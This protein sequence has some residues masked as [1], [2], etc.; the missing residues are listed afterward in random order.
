[1]A[2]LRSMDASRVK[3]SLN[4]GSWWIV[5]GPSGLRAVGFSTDRGVSLLPCAA[6]GVSRV[7]IV[8]RRVLRAGR[9][10]SFLAVSFVPSFNLGVSRVVT[11]TRRVLRTGWS[12]ALGVS[13]GV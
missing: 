1:M 2:S 13:L 12:N 11:V 10:V 6:L 4:A 5:N 7:L 9:G 3:S 8:T